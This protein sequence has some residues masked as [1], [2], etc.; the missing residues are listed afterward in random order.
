MRPLFSPL[1]L[2]RID[3]PWLRLIVEGRLDVVLL[4]FLLLPKPPRCPPDT[5]FVL[6]SPLFIEGLLP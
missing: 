5:P 4:L 6:R 3:V 2:G 1:L